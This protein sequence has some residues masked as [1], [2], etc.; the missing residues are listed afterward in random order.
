M[1]VLVVS[2]EITHRPFEGLL[3]FVMHLCRFLSDRT[4]LTVLHERGEPEEDIDARRITGNGPLAGLPLL[5]HFRNNRYKLLIYIP[6][7][8]VSRRGFARSALLKKLSGAPLCMI[9]LQSG[10]IGRLQRALAAFSHPDL[11]LSPVEDMSEEIED[12]GVKTDFM[13]PGVDTGLF[14]PVDRERSLMLRKRYSLPADRFI[15]LH[16]GHIAESRGLQAFLRYR[17][18]GPDVQPVVKAGNVDPAWAERLRQAGVI[19]IDE[20]I[21]DIHEIYQASDLYLFPVSERLGALE[22]PLSVI[23][24]ASCG[25]PVITTRFGALPSVL[26][27]CPRL[28][29]YSNSGELPSLIG[30]ARSAGASPA[31]SLPPFDLSWDSVFERYLMPHVDALSGRYDG[32]GRG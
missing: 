32:G 22:F 5:K 7:T 16:V 31:G 19:V 27:D 10:E 14:A 2:E 29:W 8:G 26:D 20:Y 1:R 17:E 18:W 12:L 28:A 6:D 13:M 9:A 30:D 3:V 23:E 24:A 15:V 4:E 11:M 25:L 21:D